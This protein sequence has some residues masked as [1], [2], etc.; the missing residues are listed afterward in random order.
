MTF[1]SNELLGYH[2]WYCVTSACHV[3]KPLRRLVGQKT[4][5]KW[6][7]AILIGCRNCLLRRFLFISWLMFEH[8]NKTTKKIKEKPKMLRLY[9]NLLLGTISFTILSQHAALGSCYTDL[10]AKGS[11]ENTM[12]P[13]TGAVSWHLSRQEMSVWSVSDGPW[14]LDVNVETAFSPFPTH[15]KLPQG[16]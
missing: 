16:P 11:V 13:L 10:W 8:L 4:P 2:L 12:V 3:T 15:P 7:H 5:Q 1:L 6:F 14:F 9:T